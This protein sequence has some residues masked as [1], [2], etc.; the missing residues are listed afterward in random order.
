MT[1]SSHAATTKVYPSTTGIQKQKELGI[2]TPILGY[3]VCSPLVGI[4]RSGY[5]ELK[6]WAKGI[7]QEANK[8]QW[9]KMWF[10]GDQRWGPRFGEKNQDLEG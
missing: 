1:T 4:A 2:G 10:F 7:G 3:E 9:T 6:A 8:R 5:L